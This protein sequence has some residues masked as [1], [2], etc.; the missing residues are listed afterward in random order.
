MPEFLK[1]KYAMKKPI[2][3]PIEVLILNG[4]ALTITSRIPKAVRITKMKPLI[5]TTTIAFPNDIL[6][7]WI[8]A[9]NM[10]LVP[11]P[12]ESANGK[13][14]KHPM[15][16]VIKPET[17]AVNTTKAPCEITTP[18]I[19]VKVAADPKPMTELGWTTKT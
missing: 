9:P 14:A 11:I 13:L 16:K 2:A 7:D 12:V 15:I 6:P 10:K 18:L 8:K 19:S 17:K 3:T 5:K 4:I 1:P